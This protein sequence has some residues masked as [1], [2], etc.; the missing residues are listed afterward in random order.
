ME[1]AETASLWRPVPHSNSLHQ[2][3]EL[4]RCE[5]CVSQDAPQHFGM[6]A[7]RLGGGD[8]GKLRRHTATSRDVRVTTA[9]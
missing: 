5:V 7:D 8:A 2:R 6:D 1:F 3:A 9:G 4:L